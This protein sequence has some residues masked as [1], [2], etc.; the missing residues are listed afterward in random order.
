MP[1]V[2][3]VHEKPKPRVGIEPVLN[4]LPWVSRDE[5][6]TLE[7][8]VK[9]V[10]EELKKVSEAS[11]NTKT[12]VEELSRVGEALENKV[13][14]LYSELNEVKS[15]LRDIAPI[16]FVSRLV[17]AWKSM[18]CSWVIE[19]VCTAWKLSEE[20]AKDIRTYFNDAALVKVNNDWRIAVKN[21]PHLCAFCPLYKP[22]NGTSA[23][24]SGT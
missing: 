19:N 11:S 12:R 18:T 23:K 2:L 24:G 22:K 3:E 10:E 8:R 4:Y 16:A 9:E 6:S 5:V 20:A 7:E 17:G 15:T 13:T 1:E 14:S 21:T